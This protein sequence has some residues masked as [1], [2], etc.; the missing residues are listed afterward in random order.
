[1]KEKTQATA[2]VSS[3]EGTAELISELTAQLVKKVEVL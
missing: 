1:M 3:I 2:I